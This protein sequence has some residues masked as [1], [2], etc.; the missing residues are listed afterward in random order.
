MKKLATSIA[1]AALALAAQ[2][3]S[4]NAAPLVSIGDTVDIFFKGGISGQYRSNVFNNPRKEDDYIGIISPGLEVN[5]GRNSNANVR[6]IFRED[7]YY[8]NEYASQNVQNANVFV[9]GVYNSGPLTSSAGFSFVQRQ[10]NTASTAGA[11]AA[12]ATNQVRTD[13]YRA[14]LK[15]EYD[16][17]PKTFATGAFEFSHIDYTNNQDFG[18]AY[19]NN[20]QY[21]TPWNVYYRYSPKLGI[22]LGY[23]F[24][25]TDVDNNSN[26]TVPTSRNPGDFLDNFVSLAIRGELYPKLT[27]RLNLGWQNRSFNSQGLSSDNTLSVLSAF[28]YTYS[29]KLVFSAGFNRDFGTGAIGQSTINTGGYISA[30]YDFSDYIAATARFGM[31]NTDYTGVTT[32]GIKRSDDTIRSSF[33]VT[34]TPNVYLQFTAAYSYIDNDSN[35]NSSSFMGHTVDLSASLRY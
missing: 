15:G 4:L 10:Q 35:I 7:L 3:S 21:S 5:I 8:Y 17:S 24:R 1:A 31:I 26:A 11:A 33:A 28:D 19:S 27:T 30:S 2:S 22:G 18:N 9:D 6:I 12:L 20:T 13:N 23:R 25:Y 32:G 14:Y 29:P 16:I 34:Y